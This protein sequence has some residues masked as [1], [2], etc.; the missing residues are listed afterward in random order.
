[1]KNLRKRI[2][3]VMISM[4]LICSMSISAGAV[5][6]TVPTSPIS[7]DDGVIKTT[8]ARAG[9]IAPL[10]LGC[11]LV[12]S[13]NLGASSG[14]YNRVNSIL[15]VF[16]SDINEKPDPYLYNYNYNLYAEE[17]GKNVV[18]NATVAEEQA[19]G[20]PATSDAALHILAH[21]PDLILNQ[22]AG[23]GSSDP[24]A[25]YSEVI[26]TLPENVDTDTS[27]DYSASY[28]TCSIS[29]LVFQCENLKNLAAVVNEVCKEKGLTTRYED[30]EV[31]AADYDK[32]VWGYYFYVQNELQKKNIS[33]KTV[34]V[35]S[36]TEDDGANWTLPPQATKVNQNKPNRLVEYTRDNTNLLNGTEETKVPLSDVLACDVVV[37]NGSAGKSLI[38]AASAAGVEEDSLPLIIDT[39]PT[40]LY[41]MI[42]QTHENALG[43]PYIQS[44]IYANE[45]DLN[46]VY[47]A[48]Y[49]YEN[50]FHI[51]DQEALQ[52][53][54]N[55]LLSS[56]TLP[57]GVTTSL[58]D[59]DPYAVEE[60]I[61]EGINYAKDNEGKRHDDPEVWIPDTSAG[62][63][64]G[65]PFSDVQENDYF[66]D[67]VNWAV[68]N[69]VTTGTTPTTFSPE[70]D[71]T[72]AQIVTFLWRAKGSPEPKST[73]NP[74]TDVQQSDYFA[75]AVLWA[76]E[77]GITKG[78][79][80]KT[81]SPN[82][83]VTRGQT[84]TFLWRM[85]GSEKVA[86]NNPFTD[87]AADQYYS[88]AVSWAVKNKVTT[89]K[90]DTLFA[91]EDPCTRAQIVTFLYRTFHPEA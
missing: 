84:V 1:M 34:A 15:G 59:Y 28:Y 64:A 38:A 7:T 50:F 19:E 45:L 12:A 23:T 76:A 30:P 81:F 42:M 37:A 48:A 43:I 26:P 57:A 17:N 51:T 5:S 77:E 32:F 3:S 40:C 89:G 46:P 33:K 25:V 67:P 52:E 75:K 9:Q 69:Q 78:S 10:I 35:V 82:D 54:V 72:R 13:S 41:G 24:N 80:E 14:D 90:T 87:V 66:F 8:A 44:I 21:R 58:A 56:A 62:I 31:I 53:T 39:L 83:T 2:A 4:V 55:T 86:A 11:N 20:T 79:S 70:E 36:K 68:Q 63:G 91:P 22:G 18:D 47:A 65:N 6:F 71:C 73:T 88:D 85:Q 49:F 16:G 74:F 27:N 61:V 60:M 29:S